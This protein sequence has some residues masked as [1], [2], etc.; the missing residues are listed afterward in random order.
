M[1]KE[2]NL[3]IE[4][5]KP[6]EIV[7]EVNNEVPSFEEFIKSYEGDVNY[8]DLN[9]SDVGTNK[10]YGP[11]SWHNS[12]CT[13]YVSDGWI[14]LN[15]GCPSCTYSAGNSYQWVHAGCGGQMY[16]SLNA[17]IKCFKPSCSRD[18]K[19]NEWGFK[20]DHVNHTGYWQATSGRALLTALSIA[21][22]MNSDDSRVM[23]MINQI[24]IKL[25]QDSL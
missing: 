20:C 10:G 17:R 7:Q 16:I 4:N 23:R 15:S 18:L 25:L 22:G 21:T 1:V 24:G 19:W 2:S 6:F 14:P 3:I 11:C 12:K 9:G 13:C 8:A 5:K